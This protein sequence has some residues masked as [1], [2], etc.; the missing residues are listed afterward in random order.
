MYEM[1]LKI[2]LKTLQAPALLNKPISNTFFISFWTKYSIQCNI[3]IV[4]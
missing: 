1:L 2:L 4:I 3:F